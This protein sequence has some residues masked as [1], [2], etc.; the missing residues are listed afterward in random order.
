MGLMTAGA[1]TGAVGGRWLGPLALP[2]EAGLWLAGTLLTGCLMVAGFAL[3]TRAQFQPEG[4]A[5]DLLA[6]IPSAPS[7]TIPSSTLPPDQIPASTLPAPTPTTSA[8][9]SMP[10]SCSLNCST[11][12]PKSLTL[13]CVRVAK[14]KK[15]AINWL[16][17][18][19]KPTKDCKNPIKKSENICKTGLFI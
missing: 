11:L 4:H 10:V 9:I 7:G 1:A 14:R 19:W 15:K 8:S 5:P 6:M 2:L 17:N 12:S 13:A 18:G 3:G 16:Q